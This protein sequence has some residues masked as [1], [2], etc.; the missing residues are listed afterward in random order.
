MQE[1]VVMDDEA[2]KALRA[3]NVRTALVIA[4]IAVLIFVAFIVRYST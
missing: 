3:R 2:Q 1:V 4:G